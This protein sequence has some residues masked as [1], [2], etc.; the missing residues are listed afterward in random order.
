MEYWKR[1]STSN[2]VIK[3]LASCF[4]ISSENLKESL[5]VN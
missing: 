1:E 3:R 2:D 4:V 5:V